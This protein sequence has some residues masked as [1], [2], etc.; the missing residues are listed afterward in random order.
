METKFTDA[1]AREI[2]S[3]INKAWWAFH[4][5]RKLPLKKRAEFMQAIGEEMD[6]L[7]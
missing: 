5:Y 3:A 6:N 1:T 2:D 7:G 4:A